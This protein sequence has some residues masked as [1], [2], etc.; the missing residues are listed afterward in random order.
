MT[1]LGCNCRFRNPR[2]SDSLY[3]SLN[4]DWFEL[5][6]VAALVNEEHAR[7]KSEQEAGNNKHWATK[8]FAVSI[9]EGFTH[10][11]IDPER[12]DASRGR[13][14][15]EASGNVEFNVSVRAGVELSQIE[16]VVAEW[17]GLSNVMVHS[18]DGSVE[19]AHV[20]SRT[21]DAGMLQVVFDNPG[22]L[23]HGTKRVRFN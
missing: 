20:T 13:V 7:V 8:D 15:L 4:V 10:L 14:W 1:G 2:L 6:E 3:P 19:R 18:V 22:H 16:V 9:P 23:F 12:C 21:S 5:D 11:N 17:T